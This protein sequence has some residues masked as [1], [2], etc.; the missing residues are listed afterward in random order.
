MGHSCPLESEFR[1][2]RCA[3]R[4]LLAGRRAGVKLRRHRPYDLARMRGRIVAYLHGVGHE[5][6]P[7][8]LGD[9]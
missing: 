8:R 6:R 1:V 3:Q 7:V 5:P 4:M 2:Q 9:T